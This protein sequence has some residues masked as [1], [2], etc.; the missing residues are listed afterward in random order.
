MRGGLWSGCPTRR[1]QMS[2]PQPMANRPPAKGRTRKNHFA[3]GKTGCPKVRNAQIP[4]QLPL[5]REGVAALPYTE[6]S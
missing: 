3:S 2:Q 6:F 5:P 1:T 4:L